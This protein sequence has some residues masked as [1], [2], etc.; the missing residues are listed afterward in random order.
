[1]KKEELPSHI[2]KLLK[3]QEAMN[4]S[5][6]KSLKIQIEANQQL[7]QTIKQLDATIA[8]LQHQ[9]ETLLRQLYGKKSERK[10][11]DKDKPD[12]SQNPRIPSQKSSSPFSKGRQKLSPDLPRRRIVH[13]LP[14]DE[15][16]C[17]DCG[18]LLSKMGEEK[19]EQYEFIPA[20]LIVLE[21]VRPKYVCRPCGGNIKVASMPYLPID[22]GLAG[23]GLL[24]E[25]LINKYED[26]LPLYRQEQRWK[27]LGVSLSRSTLCAWV[28]GCARL[29]EPLVLRTKETSMLPSSKIHVDDTPVPV[30]VKGKGKTHIGRIWVYVSGGGHTPPCT[31]Y[32]YSTTRSQE[33]PKQFLKDYK[34][35]LQADAYG[36][37]DCL[38]KSGDIIE[39][40]CWAHCRR[41]FYEIT[42]AVKKP[43]LADV[44]LNFIG[45]LYD[46]ERH[47]KGWDNQRRKFYRRRYAKP[48]LKH[49]KRWLNQHQKTTLPKSPIGQAIG[50]ALNHFRALCHY[51]R[52]GYLDIDNNTAE[53]A[54]KPLVLGRKNYLFFGSH[55]GGNHAAIIYSLIAT[56]KQHNVNTF[57]YLKDVLT[58]LP[59]HKIN[60]IDE[61]LPYNWKQKF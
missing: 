33:V 22:K 10:S 13:V 7:Q 58:R 40:T 27:R 41:K 39:C 1:M 25:V 31:V 26:A 55:E 44:A 35:Y 47:I 2:L 11:N 30:Q 51:L 24:A 36:G 43:S 19:S 23:P 17:S 37:F 5:L 3:Q 21:H 8:H 45:K 29:L 12:T 46:I 38:Y 34:G 61:L 18:R 54:I 28:A 59:S 4:A 42:Q 50:Y 20:Q 57:D 52:E 48:I 6:A 56:C 14:E 53:R 32:E 15:K 60:K 49:F 16:A 9:V